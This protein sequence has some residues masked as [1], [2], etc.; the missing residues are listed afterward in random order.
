[1][2]PLQR[3]G[4]TRVDVAIQDRLLVIA[5][6]GEAFDLLALDGLRAFVL[7]DAVA[8]EDPD[9]DDRALHSWGNAQ[10]RVAHVGGFLA[11]DGAQELFFRRH[12]ALALGRDLTDQDVACY[13]LGADV[14]DARFVEILQRLFRNVGNVAGDLLGPKLGVAGHRLEFFDVNRGEDV[15]L[16]DTL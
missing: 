13:D 10:R 7:V 6:L 14:D 1:M 5:V 9:L 15:V 16:D 11:K 3:L 12:W 2:L 4:Q 8:V